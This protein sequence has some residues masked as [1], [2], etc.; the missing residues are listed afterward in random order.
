MTL[1]MLSQSPQNDTCTRSCPRT[2]AYNPVAD[3]SYCA[4]GKDF[5]APATGTQIRRLEF[6][7]AIRGR[8]TQRYMAGSKVMP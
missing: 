4:S 8:Q 3:N 7:Q 2:I 5:V 1:P 6:P